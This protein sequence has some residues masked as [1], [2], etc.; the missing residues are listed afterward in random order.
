MV[1]RV[2]YYTLNTLVRLLPLSITEPDDNATLAARTEVAALSDTTLSEVPLAPNH[3][4]ALSLVWLADYVRA[5]TKHVEA[6]KR[7][8]TVK[9]E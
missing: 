7:M 5:F 2:I 1:S 8:V 3:D 4:V 9:D 6:V